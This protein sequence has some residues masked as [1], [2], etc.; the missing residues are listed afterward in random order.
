[1]GISRRRLLKAAALGAAA[2]PALATT[3]AVE[4][5][6]RP[7]PESFERLKPI[8]DRIRPITVQEFQQRI[9]RAQRL[10]AESKP[11]FVALFT[12]PGSTQYYFRGIRWGGGERLMALVIP[13]KGEP[14]LV[15]P[16][17]EEA[18]LRERLRWPME[19]RTWQEDESPYALVARTLAERG[20]RTGRI[21]I[22]ETT[23][24]FFFDG[25]RRAAPHYEY[26]IGDPITVGCRAQKTDRKRHV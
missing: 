7:L 23:R 8:R 11:P 16:A 21:G 25:L 15:C 5:P 20:F 6:Q 14:F 12:A 10:M 9:A 22:D 24:F 4:T 3:G 2:T 19:I 1:M 17:F 26:T 13:Q 18:T